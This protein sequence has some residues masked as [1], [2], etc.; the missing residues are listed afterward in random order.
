MLGF[1]RVQVSIF[2]V[3][4]DGS[5]RQLVQELDTQTDEEGVFP[6]SDQRGRWRAAAHRA[7]G[8]LQLAGGHHGP[9]LFT[10]Q[11]STE[12]GLQNIDH[13]WE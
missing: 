10:T 1:I 9:E 8:L 6:V 2:V 11:V 12:G 13:D 7:P 3:L 4:D 5:G